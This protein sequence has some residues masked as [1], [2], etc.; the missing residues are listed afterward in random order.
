MD[1]D[2]KDIANESEVETKAG[3]HDSHP[4][5]V[6]TFSTFV[7]SIASSALVHL[8]EV[9]DPESGEIKRNLEVAKHN[10]DILSMLK[11]KSIGNLDADELR[12]ID[13]VLYEL[14]LK[15]VMA[16]K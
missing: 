10:V 13:G 5:P 3:E 7:L 9:P 15:Y 8:G 1:E 16:D 11:E 4:M 2:R 12:L 6:V 14:R